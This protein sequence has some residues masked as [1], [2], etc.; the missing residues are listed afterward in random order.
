LHAQNNPTRS[1]QASIT[2]EHP[3][4][5][6]NTNINPEKTQYNQEKKK[7]RKLHPKHA[8]NQG[9]QYSR[10]IS[11]RSRRVMK[12]RFVAKDPKNASLVVDY[13]EKQKR[14]DKTPKNAQT[15]DLVKEN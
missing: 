6:T 12:K 5:K 9:I 1:K 10:I 4:E 7:A 2:E 15:H 3:K 14:L 11:S 13:P 8:K